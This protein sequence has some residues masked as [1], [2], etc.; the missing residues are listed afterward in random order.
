MAL[1]E[2]I[3]NLAKLRLRELR[4]EEK[5]LLKTFP[6]LRRPEPRPEP[7]RSRVWTKAQR[8]AQSKRLKAAHA[9]KKAKK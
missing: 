1:D 7:K 5:E 9:L 8:L 4:D 3:V 6:Q 2:R